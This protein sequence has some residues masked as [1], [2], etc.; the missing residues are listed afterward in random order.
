MVFVLFEVLLW[1]TFYSVGFTKVLNRYDLTAAFWILFSAELVITFL[2]VLIYDQFKRD[3][4]GIEHAKRYLKSILGI[5]TG[6]TARKLVITLLSFLALFFLVSA[7]GL[8]L[9]FRKEGRRGVHLGG[10]CFIL[11]IILTKTCVYSRLHIH[12]SPYYI[13]HH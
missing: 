10:F 13:G 9:C 11:M 6:W 4:F 12:L 7:P 3:L 8:F 2:C 1:P 5:A